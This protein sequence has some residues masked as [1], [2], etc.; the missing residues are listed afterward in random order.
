[1]IMPAQPGDTYLDYALRY[2]AAFYLVIL[3][4]VIAVSIAFTIYSLGFFAAL[5]VVTEWFSPFNVTGFIVNLVS[6]L[7]ALI[8]IYIVDRRRAARLRRR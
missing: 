6:T 2:F 7:P 4:S 5:P 3:V 1:M 8:P